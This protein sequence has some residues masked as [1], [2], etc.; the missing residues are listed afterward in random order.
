MLGRQNTHGRQ[1]RAE[2]DIRGILC[3]SEELLSNQK[4]V[5]SQVAGAGPGSE[6]RDRQCG[7]KQREGDGRKAP[8]PCW[9]SP[10]PGLALSAGEPWG[11]RGVGLSGRWGAGGVEG[12]SIPGGATE[13]DAWA[14]GSRLGAGSCDLLTHLGERPTE[15][16][17]VPPP[18][19][20][21]PYAPQQW[22]E[23][24]RD[25]LGSSGCPHPV[26]VL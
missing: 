15:S 3:C 16:L 25:H 7:Q 11:V 4:A 20:S 13:D 6:H 10:G 26:M 12:A 5:L 23:E 9:L 21:G 22:G 18:C 2:E 17:G 1:G 8:D 14:G 19:S 24:P